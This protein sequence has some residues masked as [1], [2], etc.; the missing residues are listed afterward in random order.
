MTDGGVGGEIRGAKGGGQGVIYS[1][2][3]QHAP[4][5]YRCMLTV[6]A[7]IH[8]VDKT[9][10]VYEFYQLCVLNLKFFFFLLSSSFIPHLGVH[11]EV[12]INMYP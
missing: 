1:G 6:T 3:C 4:I 7:L 12:T 2:N 5:T 8:K 11:E 10:I 9:L